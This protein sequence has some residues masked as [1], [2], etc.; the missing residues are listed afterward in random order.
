[1]LSLSA[2][3][4]VTGEHWDGLPAMLLLAA[5]LILLLPPMV[6]TIAGITSANYMPGG[7][8]VWGAAVGLGLGVAATAI[9]IV[10]LFFLPF[11]PEVWAREILCPEN[12]SPQ[13]LIDRDSVCSKAVRW[14]ERGFWIGIS[15]IA[16]TAAAGGTW[17]L[18]RRRSPARK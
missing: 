9:N 11:A 10:G 7:S 2:Q 4:T 1:M 12:M 3:V 14:A 18:C 17:W 6:A 8:V 13:D 16:P 15:L 5:F